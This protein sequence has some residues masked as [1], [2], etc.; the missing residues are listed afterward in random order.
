MRNML[1]QHYPGVGIEKVHHVIQN[2]L[3]DVQDF[4]AA[5][6]EFLKGKK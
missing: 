1:V 5:I 3:G 6:T 4:C 2:D